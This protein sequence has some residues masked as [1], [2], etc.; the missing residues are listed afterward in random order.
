MSFLFDLE[1]PSFSLRTR[2]ARL[3]KSIV[4][5]ARSYMRF[6]DHQRGSLANAYI[7]RNTSRMTRQSE[8]S[9]MDHLRAFCWD[10]CCR[11]YDV[12]DMFDS[13]LFIMMEDIG[14]IVGGST[15]IA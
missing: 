10:P 6:G 2:I 12:E 7:R 4:I 11:L 1:E 3:L 14:Y 8:D 13:L 15:E 5:G 9:K